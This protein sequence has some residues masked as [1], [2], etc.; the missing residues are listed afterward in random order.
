MLSEIP[1][2]QV[3]GHNVILK[4]EPKANMLIRKAFQCKTITPS[5]PTRL[6]LHDQVL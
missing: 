5:P 2:L 4:N 3:L 1:F 6:V